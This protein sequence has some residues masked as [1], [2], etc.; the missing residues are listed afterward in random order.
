[1]SASGS[2][3]AMAM[4]VHGTHAPNLQIHAPNP[5]MKAPKRVMR[6]CDI[7]NHYSINFKLIVPASFPFMPLKV[8]RIFGAVDLVKPRMSR[9]LGVA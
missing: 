9:N 7:R 2:S 4:P 5:C 3:F 8:S 1:M 6:I